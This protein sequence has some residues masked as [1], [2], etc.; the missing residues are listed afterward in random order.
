MRA[1]ECRSDIESEL[2]SDDPTGVDD[3][4]FSD[5][6]ESQEVV[7]TSAERHDPTATT[8]GEE[9]EA[10]AI[11]ALRKCAASMDAIGGRAA[12][13]TRSPRPLAVS[14]VPSSLMADAV[15]QA[16]L[17]EERTCPCASPGPMPMCDLRPGETLPAMD[18]VEQAGW[19]EG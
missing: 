19:S 2:A 6:E 10:T 5:E 16:G 17:S 9:Q 13:R 12:K 14:P 1:G 15:E 3:L 8:V 11:P 18:V 7:V 4:V